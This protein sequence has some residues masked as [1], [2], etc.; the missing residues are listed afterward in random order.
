[1]DYDEKKFTYYPT[2]T[3]NN[4]TI[5]TTLDIWVNLYDGQYLDNA[6]VI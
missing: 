5:W 2:V 1:M 6:L 3:I 4:S